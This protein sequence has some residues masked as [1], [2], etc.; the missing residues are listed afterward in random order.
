MNTVELDTAYK[1][2]LKVR[3][4]WIAT[5]NDFSQYPEKPATPGIAV[6]RPIAV[7]G[8][9]ETGGSKT[10]E[11]LK[12]LQIEWQRFHDL[13]ESYREKKVS[14]IP[15]S[16]YHPV[17]FIAPECEFAVVN[18]NPGANT[19]KWYVEKVL[20]LIKKQINMVTRELKCAAP[21]QAEVMEDRLLLLEADLARFEK[22]PEG[23]KL[24]R[25]QDGYVD[26]T[27]S[28]K[29]AATLEEV[30]TVAAIFDGFVERDLLRVGQY[31]CVI[32]EPALKY[33]LAIYDR[34]AGKG[35][36][37]R[38]IY[39]RIKP[40]P[41]SVMASNVSLYFLH[42]VEEAKLE[43]KQEAQIKKRDTRRIYAARSYSNLLAKQGKSVSDDHA[44]KTATPVARRAKL[45]KLAEPIKK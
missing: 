29:D 22:I 17:P 21:G 7:I 4:E 8:G 44:S 5:L 36:A 41:C 14:P 9:E 35:E 45:S 1:A 33:K 28:L 38:N 15:K 37:I 39:D 12:H 13:A 20:S 16:M 43:V 11:K 18:V 32:Q 10:L 40:I 34:S 25:R 31:G 27:V 3:Q 26:V 42:E 2:F 23:T 30:N 6:S 19:V 24:V